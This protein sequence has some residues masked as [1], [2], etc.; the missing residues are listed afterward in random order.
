[1][2]EANANGVRTKYR[3]LGWDPLELEAPPV[4]V[5][6]VVVGPELG[7][8]IATASAARSRIV[9]GLSSSPGTRP[10]PVL[11]R[12]RAVAQYIAS[13]PRLEQRRIVIP[14]YATAARTSERARRRS[15]HRLTAKAR[16]EATE[17]MRGGRARSAGRMV[18]GWSR[19]ARG[20]VAGGQPRG[21][22]E[23]LAPALR[24]VCFRE[25]KAPPTAV[26]PPPPTGGCP[27]TRTP[28][29]PIGDSPARQLAIS[30][31]PK[32]TGVGI[33]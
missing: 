10:R 21:G 11:L 2:P 17:R 14:R 12:G 8:S 5:V 22:E 18:G 9:A 16:T 23:L 25:A 1:M 32:G 19:Q 13:P 33:D 26:R 3:A 28:E 20:A 30:R 27:R 29:L 4:V 15:V 24:P 7:A 6:V 31:F